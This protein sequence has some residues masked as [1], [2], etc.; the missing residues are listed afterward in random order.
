M[1][2]NGYIIIGFPGVGKSTVAKDDTRFIDLESSAFMVDDQRSEDWYKTYVNVAVDLTKYHN[3]LISSH[4]AVQ[5]YLATLNYNN[6]I[7]VYPDKSLKTVWLKRLSKRYESDPS[8]KNKRAL[9]YM[10]SNFDTC[11]DDMDKSN[12]FMKLRLNSIKQADDLHDL[13]LYVIDKINTVRREDEVRMKYFGPEKNMINT[14][15]FSRP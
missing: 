7:M 12:N 13:I 6:V 11:V 2:N 4:M 3:V 15:A 10:E 1:N 5:N 9:D 8:D 14:D